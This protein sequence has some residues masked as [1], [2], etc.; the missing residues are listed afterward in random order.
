MKTYFQYF[1]LDNLLMY[2]PIISS[3]K[4]DDCRV[5]K[6]ILFILSEVKVLVIKDG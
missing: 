4:Y 5:I 6:C 2:K 3:K 1:S